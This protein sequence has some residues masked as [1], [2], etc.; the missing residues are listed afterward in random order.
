MGYGWARIATTVLAIC[1]ANHEI[2]LGYFD[3]RAGGKGRSAALSQAQP[4]N[5]S[6]YSYI[7]ART[8][9]ING[10][11]DEASA[12]ISRQLE[13]S[14]DDEE[15]LILHAKIQE[16]IE[17]QANFKH[18]NRRVSML[19]N[20]DGAWKIDEPS[21]SQMEETI[22]AETANSLESK[23]AKIIIPQARFIN[24]PISQAI[25]AITELSIRYDGTADDP[26]AKGANIVLLRAGTEVE[27]KIT[28]NLRNLSLERLLFYVSQA[29]NYRCEYTSDA[30]II[31]D[32]SIVHEQVETK[33][34]PVARATVIR[35]TGQ[36]S[37]DL[38]GAAA[39]ILEEEAAIRSFFTRAGIEFNGTNGSNLAFDGTQLIVTHTLKNLR[40]IGCILQKYSKLR[41][42]E[43][44][45]K[46]LEV[47]QG[48]LDELAFRWNAMNRRPNGKPERVDSG[49][50]NQNGGNIDNLRTL[51]QAFAPSN[52]SSGN[53]Q[54][55]QAG[56]NPIAINN[57]PPN[58]PGQIN[59][60]TSSVPFGSFLGVID[61]AQVNLMIRALEQKT[62][63]DLMSAP[64]LTVLSGKTAHIIVAQE[65]RYPQ[66]YGETHS[67]VGS[68][69]SLNNATSAGVTITSGTPRDFT[70]RN[71]GVE[72]RVTP[73]VENDTNIS[74]QLEP[75]VTEF[76]GFMEYGGM[77]VAVSGGATV[78][79]PSGFYQPIFSTR[80]IRTEVTVQNGWTVVMG[81]LT[82]EEV[83][84]VRDKI[85]LLG[86]IPLIGKLFR[87]KSET[88]QK[89]NLLIFVTARTV[90]PNGA[91]VQNPRIESNFR[92][93]FSP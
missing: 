57:Q 38:D 45:A 81:G 84:E 46:F 65:L 40:R 26:Q 24:L 36:R 48:S 60:G 21:D 37:C 14:P 66:S 43:I 30:V 54:I 71:V 82:R 23:L 22:P 61:R 35:L 75:K 78:Y 44:E 31:G 77:S 17:N 2:A 53:G 64:K 56:S 8:F 1:L 72:M 12:A 62:G 79:V 18:S 13:L 47:S 6:K 91:R 73:I 87:S 28:L 41:Q 83:K 88:V 11:L 25:E 92:K 20:V 52:S 76:E 55:I 93:V 5:V 29:A 85:P 32:A 70:T 33:I 86:D 80:E 19:N 74:L 10:D 7:R 16:T 9:F 63:S 49:L 15:S 58:L 68:G 89:R 4:Q 39:S 27:P 67:E 34:F 51:A 69:S 90:S 42:V 3:R 50:T 59:I